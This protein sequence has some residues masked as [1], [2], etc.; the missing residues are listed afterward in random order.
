MG[1]ASRWALVASIG[2]FGLAACSAVLGFETLSST[3]SDAGSDAGPPIV[4]G[5]THAGSRKGTSTGLRNAVKLAEKQLNEA[6]GVLG[7]HVTFKTLDDGANLR[8]SV[9]TL[10]DEDHVTA[11]L[12]PAGNDE[13]L[14]VVNTV[15][16]RKVIEISA[17]ATAPDLTLLASGHGY[18][19]RTAP[20]EG[21]EAKVLANFAFAHASSEAGATGC[22]RLAIVHSDDSYGDSF[23]QA[24]EA[25]FKTLG[26]EIVKQIPTAADV[27][28]TYQ[29]EL[30]AVTTPSTECLAMIVS[31]PVGDEFLREFVA[32]LKAD[33]TRP[34]PRFIV[35]AQRLHTPDF[36]VNGRVAKNDT[37]SPTIAEGIYGTSP[38]PNPATSEYADFKKSY[39]AQF[40]LEPGEEDLPF[41]VAGIYD[42]AILAALAI[43]QAGSTDDPAKIRDA[44][45]GVSAHGSKKFGPALVGEALA[46]IRK[47]EDIDYVGASGDVDFDANGA[48]I[49]DYIVWRVED[50]QFKTVQRIKASELP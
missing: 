16:G 10:L 18:F 7:R 23:S 3:S 26:G 21:L 40:S 36:I 13:A 2:V 43:E 41:G 32:M 49:S 37:T 5:V 22:L 11:L 34:R 33:P 35:G 47:Q 25:E 28:P 1:R 31:D 45:F 44:M 24:M 17:T 30:A 48:V 8:T 4:I 29:S 6:G 12:G 46:A 19:F 15:G 14:S 9:D 27:A 20:S 39:L 50:G 38:D 42:A